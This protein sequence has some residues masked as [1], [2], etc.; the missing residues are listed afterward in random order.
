MCTASKFVPNVVC[1]NIVYC[2]VSG[3][4]FVPNLLK[5]LVLNR[6]GGTVRPRFF[7]F[8]TLFSNQSLIRRAFLLIYFFDYKVFGIHVPVGKL[9][10]NFHA[11]LVVEVC[12]DRVQFLLVE[13]FSLHERWRGCTSR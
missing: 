2:V 8:F 5:T 6:F 13:I 12:L 7:L 3:V 10:A 4:F 9:H 11:L 1:E